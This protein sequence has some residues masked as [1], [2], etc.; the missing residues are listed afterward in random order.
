MKKQY[1]LL[2]FIALFLCRSNTSR[3]QIVG[4]DVFLQGQW[5][6]IGEITN[7]SFGTHSVPA[8][9]HPHF[10]PDLAEVY[11]YGHDGWGVGA[12]P[13]MGD[14]TYPGS[15][16]E[17]WEIQ[18]NGVRNQAYE[19]GGFTGSCA[20][21]GTL[22]GTVTGYSNIGGRAISNWTGSAAPGNVLK[23][24]QETRVDTG[25]SWV[26]V[27]TKMY[28]TSAAPL[29]AVYYMRSCDPDNDETW[30]GGSFFTNNQVDYQ[31][32]PQHRVLVEAT[33]QTGVYT[34]WGLGTRDC[35]AVAAV[36]NSWPL[37]GG[38]DLATIWNQTYTPASY[39]VGVND[40]GDIGIILVY[41][42]GT[43]AANDSAAVSYAYIFGS[44]TRTTLI[45][46]AFPDP[47]LT[48][49]NVPVTIFP[50]TFDACSFPTLDS[51]PLGIVFGEDKCWTWGKWT[52]SP[53]VALSSSAGDT[54]WAYLNKIPGYVTFTVTGVDSAANMFSCNMKTFVFTIKSCH[55]AWNNSPCYG[56][57]L[58]LGMLGDSLGATYKWK[59]PAG[60]TSTLHDPTIFPA[61]FA[62]SGEYYVY[63]TIAGV[64]D[65][66]STY[67][68]IHPKPTVLVSDN[69]PLCLGILDTL[70]LQVT[71]FTGGET[72]KWTGPAAFTSTMEFPTVPGFGPPNVGTY[73]VIATTAFGC[74]DTGTVYADTIP[75]PHPPTISGPT[76]YCQFSPFVRFTITGDTSRAKIFLWYTSATGGVGDTTFPVVNTSAVGYTTVWAT[77]KVGSCES[78]RSSYTVR[79]I[80][81]P[82]APVV[83]GPMSYCQ[84]IGP[85]D[86]VSVGKRT[87]TAV[88]KW[89]TTAMGLAY[90][91]AEPIVDLS[92]A[93]AH[94]YW[95]SILDSGCE[96][97]RTPIT[98]I[99]NPKPAPPIVTPQWYCLNWPAGPLKAVP[100]GTGDLL[101]WFGPG[102]PT[103]GTTS[104]PIPA[105]T[106]VG[107]VIDSVNEKT[108]FGC[109]SNMAIDTVTIRPIP[110]VPVTRD[111]AYCQFTQAPAL[112][113]DST[114]GD[115]LRWYEAGVLLPHAPKPFN[116]IPGD[117]TWYVA[118]FFNGCESDSTP[119]TVTTIYKPNFTITGRP[120]VCQF[121][122]ITLSFNGATLVDPS[123]T[124]RL[125]FGSYFA[126]ITEGILS[127]SSDSLVMARFDTVVENNFVF[128]T[129]TDNHGF[130]STTDSIRIKIV[131]EPFATSYSKPD[132]CVGDTV[133][134]VLSSKSSDAS[135]FVWLID[136]VP[137][138]SSSSVNII[139]GS[140]NSGGP[141]SISWIDSGRHVVQ[142]STTT[143]E[144]CKDQP[145]NDTINVH[146]MPDAS[147]KVTTSA[148][149]L[150]LEDSVLFTANTNN[151]N[152]SYLWA[153]AHF[154]NN[155]NQ[156][157]IHGRVEQSKSIVTLTVT[158]PFG[159]VASNSVELD[160]GTC[161]TV[162]F[163]NA[164]S[165]DGDRH[166]DLFKPIF[167][168]Y[169]RFHIF[170]IANR[171]G[172]TVYESTNDKMQWDGTFNG[173]PQDVGVY[174]Y[175]IKF[176]C[177]GNTMEQT[178]DVTLIR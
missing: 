172:Q 112:T 32:D 117:S 29:P 39:A 96:S 162:S 74:K 47:I 171:W 153:P 63:K 70:A 51:V 27:T 174:Y 92:V 137:F 49:N 34:R 164:F 65:T 140:S 150:C 122:S 167:A 17:G 158:D 8:G 83:T 99:V 15:P 18:I 41:N 2:V 26:V 69:S 98:I 120:W 44:N 60:F 128:L 10:G 87:S 165:P 40:P 151:Y 105:T 89:F 124:W 33:G 160:P 31:N 101:T 52:W 45:D 125:P 3:A 76:P 169:H 71:P 72:F 173:V 148:G 13:F 73:T 170:R 142:V 22:T 175:Y 100:S 104:T 21:C 82:A 4:T 108:S 139:S 176:D 66:D 136:N 64:I 1:I 57:K 155:V 146:T 37:S 109:I 131:P 119:I 145:L 11:D 123:Y 14:Y 103:G 116:T 30:P 88:V 95:V 177:G 9:Y 115:R 135:D 156:P 91:F 130:C 161:C 56:D 61:I 111:T 12:P 59:G 86:T 149:S 16:F 85:F 68:I 159:C 114:P 107:Y 129:A 93:G 84:Y 19:Y 134:L 50:D 132:V 133:Q 127:K 58:L 55:S 77:E 106:T 53:S 24:Y 67:V 163:P 25:A 79:V 81:T 94:N 121:D 7:G 90:T 102:I 48:I 6:E 113:A 126:H 54:V 118:Q 20:P 157:V 154:F 5:L 42:I 110:A 147:F 23:I 143:L 28:N 62:D 35:R 78:N 97:A 168:G 36:Y 141:Y 46:S 178:G 43:I 166:N 80:T 152:Y 75:Q 138:G 38:T 144:G